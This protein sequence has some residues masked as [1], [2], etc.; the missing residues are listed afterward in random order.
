MT[1]KA[2]RMIVYKSADGEEPWEPVLVNE[3]PEWL[4]APD[5]MAELHGGMMAHSIVDG[6]DA[7]WY[8]AE[9]TEIH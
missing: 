1:N 8:R 5:T 7:P 9:E 4:K 2:A 6:P 3:V